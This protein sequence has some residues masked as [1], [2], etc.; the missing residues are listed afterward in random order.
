MLPKGY[1]MM[2]TP[3]NILAFN[4][5]PGSHKLSLT[6]ARTDFILS[7]CLFSKKLPQ[8][9]SNY[10]LMLLPR[11]GAMLRLSPLPG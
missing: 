11:R 10:I 7:V 8:L 3:Q 6:E 4:E 2:Y 1:R 5:R 9:K